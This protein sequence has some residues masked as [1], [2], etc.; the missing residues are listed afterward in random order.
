MKTL[1]EII[2]ENVKFYRNKTKLSQM[3]LAIAIEMAPSYLA[4]IEAGRQ[5]PSLHIV[6]KLANFFE[7]QPYELLYPKELALEKAIATDYIQ[8]LRQMKELINTIIDTQINKNQT[9]NQN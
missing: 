2:S 7:I 4:E 9:E 5:L 8:S 6:Q 1:E 3:K